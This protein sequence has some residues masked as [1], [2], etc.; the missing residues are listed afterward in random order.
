MGTRSLFGPLAVVAAA[1]ASLALAPAAGAEYQGTPGK[2]AYLDNLTG[3][4]PATSRYPLKIWDPKDGGGVEGQ[5]LVPETWH[6]E[7][8]HEVV[9]GLPSA[10]VFSP[11]GTE[12]AFSALV[13]DPGIPEVPG[14][15]TAIFLMKIDGSDKR[16]LTFPP[17]A[18]VPPP[19]CEGNCPTHV[20]SDYAPSWSPDGKEI[21][22]I[23]QVG[24]NEEDAHYSERFENV[25]K[26]PISGGGPTQIT[27]GHEEKL[28]QSV[29]W[30][31]TGIFTVLVEAGNGYVIELLGQPQ[32][33]AE[34]LVI[35]DWDVSPDGKE[36]T[37]SNPFG[38]FAVD[39][40]GHGEYTLPTEGEGIAP[41]RYSPAGN[42]ALLFDCG[43]FQNREQRSL[44]RCG[45]FEEHI[46]GEEGEN[47]FYREGDPPDR[48][49]DDWTDFGG[50]ISGFAPT[51]ALW[52]VQAQQVPVIY[53]PGFLASTIKGCQSTPPWPP[54]LTNKNDMHEMDLES[55]GETNADCGSAGPTMEPSGEILQ[56]IE[57]AGAFPIKDVTKTL[58][59]HMGELK[60]PEPLGPNA[61]ALE[62]R[63]FPTYYFGWDWRKRAHL[64]VEDLDKYIT[65]VL[66]AKLQE[67]EGVDR[68]T[69][70]GHSYGGLLIR[71]YAE[72]HHDRI[73]RILTLGTPYWGAPKVLFPLAFGRESPFFGLGM[74]LFTNSDQ[75]Q[76]LARNLAGLYELFPSF[77]RYGPWLSVKFNKLS[78][79][80]L[81]DLIKSFGGSETLYGEAQTDHEQVFDGFETGYGQIE[82]QV[83]AG[84]GLPTPGGINLRFLGENEA[85]VDVAMENGDT[86]VP[87][88]SAVQGSVQHPLGSPV[89][90]QVI[91][92]VEHMAEPNSEEFFK[93][94]EE[95]FLSGRAPHKLGTSCND[96]SGSVI[97][98]P[99][100][101]GIH[102]YGSGEPSL[103]SAPELARTSGAE[104]SGPTSIADA[105]E[106]G[107]ID[108]YE[109]NPQLLVVTNHYHSVD[110]SI[111]VENEGFTYTPVEPDGQNGTPL[112]YEPVSGNLEIVPGIGG[113]APAVTVDGEPVNPIGSEGEGE[114]SEGEGSG[115]GGGGGESSGGGGGGS[116][117]SGGGGNGHSPRGKVRV[118]QVRYAK[119]RLLVKVYVSEPGKVR[120]VLR[121]GEKRVAVLRGRAGKAGVLTLRGKPAAKLRRKLRAR[122]KLKLIVTLV[123]G[124]GKPTTLRATAH[125]RAPKR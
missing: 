88:R 31:R 65:Q 81:R 10:P 106:A 67:E 113:A 110:L 103:S 50:I 40:L 5:V 41:I 112:S 1:L 121:L 28:Y 111:E 7:E 33:L 85:H 96:A 122:A 42:G 98:F 16:Q 47:R 53:V 102:I 24:A 2:I 48:L 19:E 63:D 4:G 6:V 108:A 12:I 119:R 61:S 99:S 90:I 55:N 114:S 30:A 120:V 84:G 43:E 26:V 94:Y 100:K 21:A 101:D 22:F 18:L 39:A 125:L 117:G 78:D 73:A 59:K 29:V 38:D 91:C 97:D 76:Q 27:H 46:E 72:E 62:G 49:L 8:E 105:A 75:M 79:A 44:R 3:G 118:R 95:W 15:H 34:P 123:P 11:D 66:E 107:E 52:D 56:Q 93:A 116:G 104:G 51:R 68:V 57:L 25:W 13:P 9:N 86:T 87:L 35:S 82:Y 74:D 23:R 58:Q 83:V 20:I 77:F 124:A 80:E 71:D 92:G 89:P 69:L 70:F 32:P 109:L 17:Q 45:L 115:G 37:Y 36:V 64:S 60:Y 14:F 54:T